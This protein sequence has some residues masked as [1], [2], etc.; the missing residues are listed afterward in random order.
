[1]RLQ[2]VLHLEG[3]LVVPVDRCDQV[4]EGLRRPVSDQFDGAVSTLE[5]GD[6]F[7]LLEIRHT[8][9]ATDYHKPKP[10]APSAIA[11]GA[12][13]E[14]EAPAGGR[15]QEHLD[16]ALSGHLHF[17]RYLTRNGVVIRQFFL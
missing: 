15:H 2:R 14:A 9:I 17:E 13:R 1:Q 12:P 7:L 4:R 6:R 10:S 16:G 5:E 8:P 3:A 11:S